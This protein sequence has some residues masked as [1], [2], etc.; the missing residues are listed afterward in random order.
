MRIS[1]GLTRPALAL[2]CGLILALAGCTQKPEETAPTTPP[3]GEQAAAPAGAAKPAASTEAPTPAASTEA[4]KPAASKAP[5][6]PAGKGK[7]RTTASG[8]KIE[9]LKE[10]TG[11]MPKPGQTV[12]VHYT[13][14][15]KD[16]KKFDSSR[17]RGQPF[18]FVLGQG[19]VIKGWDEGIALMK[20]GERANLIIPGDLGYGPMGHPPDIP[21]DA[22]L[23][24]DVELVAIK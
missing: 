17:D 8:L 13:G 24:F 21:P 4:A 5:A 23:H 11:P 2:G 16:G 22:E 9:V 19:N 6:K 10:G 12:L 18:D 20:V 7:T 3:V 14:T 15:L 1:H